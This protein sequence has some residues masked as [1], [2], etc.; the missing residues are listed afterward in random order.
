MGGWFGRRRRS[1]G[2]LTRGP[3]SSLRGSAVETAFVDDVTVVDDAS[4][5]DWIQPSLLEWG[6][7]G[8]P[9]CSIVPTGYESYARIFHAI[10]LEESRWT[11]WTDVAARTGREVHAGMQWETISHPEDASGSVPCCPMEGSP[12]RWQAEVLAEVLRRNTSTPDVCWMAVWEGYG[13]IPRPDSPRLR[14]PG[15]D[16]ILLRGPLEAATRPLWEIV[17]H[18]WGRYQSPNL[19]WPDDRAWV[20]GTEIDFAWTY[21]GGT[22]ECVEA[23]VR[24]ERL[25][26]FQVSE[27]DRADI[28][29]DELNPLP[30]EIAR[31]GRTDQ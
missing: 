3:G 11:S 4:V 19:W 28:H 21:V 9:T 27:E 12:P 22:A 29:G 30:P 18:G 23:I 13:D 17:D 25:E 15:R 1:A 7:Q 8:T 2:W 16:Y 5:A 20:V 14:L 24:N 26:A 10:E 31:R 6:H